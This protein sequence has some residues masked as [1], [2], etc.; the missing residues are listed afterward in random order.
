[1]SAFQPPLSPSRASLLL[2]LLLSVGCDDD[3]RERD[4]SNDACECPE[5]Q[6]CEL[7]CDAPPCNV[8]CEADSSCQATCANGM[9]SCAAGAVC[10][11]SCGAPPCH[12]QCAGDNERCD[13]TCA[14]GSCVCGPNSSC[15]FT[16][17]SGPCHAECPAGASCVVLCPNAPAGT[18]DCNITQCA[19]GAPTICPG[20]QATTCDAECP[21]LDDAGAD[22]DAR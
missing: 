13:G 4:C 22:A 20:A 1:M 7:S 21:A 8:R 10:E 6:R 15:A 9:C 5:G 3:G 12:V 19:S 17:Q 11:F 14:N 18:Q 16:C 2:A